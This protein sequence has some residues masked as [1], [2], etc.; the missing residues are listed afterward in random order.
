MS[1]VLYNLKDYDNA[2]DK[3]TISLEL[4]MNNYNAWYMGGLILEQIDLSQESEKCFEISRELNKNYLSIRISQIEN[5][6]N[7][8]KECLKLKH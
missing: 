5:I 1:S 8:E 2:I 7:E 6:P 4:D 3:L